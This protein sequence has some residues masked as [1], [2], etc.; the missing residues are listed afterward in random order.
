MIKSLIAILSTAMI[1]TACSRG[2][3]RIQTRSLSAINPTTYSFPLPLQVVRGRAL[4]AFSTDHQVKQPVFGHSEPSSNLEKFFSV[5]CSTN[6]VVGATIFSDPANTNDLYLHTFHTP[7][8]RSSVY[9]GKDGGLPFIAAFH[10]HLSETGS[11]T[12]I[13]I[14]ASDTQVIN[15]TKF[16]FGSCGPGKAWNLQNVQPTTVEEYSILRYLGSYLG[17]ANMPPVSLPAQH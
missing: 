11:N 4:E 12:T 5:E 15:G 3:S 1:S 13:T 6:A 8:V 2:V 9:Y 7:F 14:T 10:L 17:V 16:G